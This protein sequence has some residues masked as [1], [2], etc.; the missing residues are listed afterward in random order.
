MD[1]AFNLA[2]AR[3]H[4]DTAAAYVTVHRKKKRREVGKYS[5]KMIAGLAVSRATLLSQSVE[6]KKF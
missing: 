1:T 5:R 2:C 3:T 6:Q 4:V